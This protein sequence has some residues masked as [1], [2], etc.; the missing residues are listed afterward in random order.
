MAGNYFTF[1]FFWYFLNKFSFNHIVKRFFFMNLNNQFGDSV[2]SIISSV[3]KPLCFSYC[4]GNTHCSH[5]LC[6]YPCTNISTIP[7]PT[8]YVDYMMSF[9]RCK[10]KVLLFLLFGSTTDVGQGLPVPLVVGLAF[11]D[12]LIPPIAG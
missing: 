11:S 2:G 10:L 3:C 12:L 8:I 7:P 6:G 4:I 1:I 9:L 5:Y